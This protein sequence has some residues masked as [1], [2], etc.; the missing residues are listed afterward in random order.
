MP[1]LS[2]IIPVYNVAKYLADG[3]DTLLNQQLEDIEIICVDDGSTDNSLDIIKEYSHKDKRIVYIENETNGGVSRTRNMG[4]TRAVG[5]YVAFFDP[6]DSVD[7]DMYSLMISKGGNN[8]IIMCGYETFPESHIVLPNFLPYIS[9]SPID[10][11]K[12][13]KKIHSTTDLCFPWRFVFKRSFLI[14]NKLKFIE[15]IRFCEDM[16]FNL[17]AILRANSIILIPLPLYKYRTNNSQ[18]IMRQPYKEYMEEG[19]QLQV[20]EKKKIISQYNLDNYT[21]ITKDMSEDIVKRYTAMLFNNLKNNSSEPNK[22]NGVKRIICMPMI[23]E[24]VREIGYRNIFPSFKE[25]IFYLAIKL[26]ISYVVYKL[27]FK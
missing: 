22:L 12:N 6:D 20:A 15:S 13:N 10:F 3:L 9:L 26:R 1:I 27:Y 4:L 23:R 19:L 14:Q 17:S 2:I 16:P 18:S 5:D 8:D 25:Y 7:N 21:P 11:I 24:A